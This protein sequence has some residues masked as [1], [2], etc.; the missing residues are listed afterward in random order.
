MN[1]ND[2]V[3]CRW[4]RFRPLH[5]RHPGRSSVLVRYHN[6]LHYSSLLGQIVR[7]YACTLVRTSCPGHDPDQGFLV[8]SGLD[9]GE[10]EWPSLSAGT[11]RLPS[12]RNSSL[13]NPD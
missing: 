12:T 7:E 10:T 4:L 1:L 9:L 2:D 3:V 5:Q 11:E 8:S 6:R 13:P